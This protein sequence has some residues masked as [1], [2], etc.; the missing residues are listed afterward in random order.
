MKLVSDWVTNQWSPIIFQYDFDLRFIKIKASFTNE[1]FE[2]INKASDFSKL[3]LQNHKSDMNT[4]LNEANF[5]KI[6]C[7]TDRDIE[8]TIHMMRNY[9]QTLYTRWQS[10]PPRSFPLRLWSVA[11]LKRPKSK[12]SFLYFCFKGNTGNFNFNLI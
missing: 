9:F 7:M 10:L 11:S 8:Y 2:I 1:H 5:S 4:P 3:V 12:L 6:I